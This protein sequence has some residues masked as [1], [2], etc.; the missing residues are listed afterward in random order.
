MAGNGLRLIRS[1]GMEGFSGSLNE[2]QISPSNTG[3]IFWG[4]LVALSS[5]YL[6]EATGGADNADFTPL[7]VFYGCHYIDADG[8]IEFSRHWNG[9]SGRTNVRAYVALPAHGNFLIKGHT[10][11]T[12]TQAAIGARFGVNYDAGSAVYGDSR[13]SLG[14]AAAASTGPLRVHRLAPYPGNT[15]GQDQPLFEV[16]LVR[17]Q[18]TAAAL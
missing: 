12:Y 7:G 8:G 4:D 14:D 10:G 6:V 15:I 13:V 3:S 17:Q 5:G 18:L 16:S 9:G 2:F 1:Q 11:V